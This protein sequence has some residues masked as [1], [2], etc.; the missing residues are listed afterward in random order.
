[1]TQAVAT[2]RDGDTFQARFFWQKAARMLIANTHISRVGF[3]K[4][5][6]GFDDVWVEYLGY[7]APK[8]FQGLSILRD[9]YQCKWHVT[10]GQYGYR[11]IVD[12]EFINATSHSLL[13]RAR[14]AQLQ[15]A[16]DGTGCRFRL[17]TNW[18]IAFDDPLRELI[19]QRAHNLRLDRMYQGTTARSA[20]GQLRQLW[21]DHLNIPDE[22][23][24]VL[25][26]TLAFTE[27]TESLDDGRDRLNELFHT[28]GLKPIRPNES[29]C[30]YDDLAFQWLAQGR[31]VFDRSTFYAACK[32]E[33]LLDQGHAAPIVFGVKSFEHPTDILEERC[34][35]V[36]NLLP[37]FYDRQIRPESAWETDLYP[38]LRAFLIASAKATDRLRLALDAHVT[39]A[40][41]TGTILD[42]KSGRIIEIEQRTGARQIWA[43]D[44]REPSKD[45]CSLVSTIEKSDETSHDI[46]VTV[47]LTRDVEPMVRSYM[48]STEL[49]YR[50]RLSA[51]P[52]SGP[53]SASVQCG[54]HAV[55]LAEEL[56]RRIGDQRAAIGFSGRVHLFLAVPNGFAFF[57]GQRLKPA[58]RVILYEYD[59]EGLNGGSYEPSLGLPVGS[60]NP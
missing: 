17:Y 33:G 45:W 8:D 38:E 22:A 1:M 54:R 30:I 41:A 32:E 56:M 9:H 7:A 47:S 43:P 16:P 42:V 39:L 26:R 51:V 23:L 55:D 40:V 44:D 48:E 28:A 49:K 3:E 25:A 29:S 36:L 24:R 35:A 37:K 57:L 13:Q 21:R 34:T 5:P 59:F 60:R 58:G 4:G 2:R 31:L 10:S 15:Y 12:P 20:S 50:V 53:G 14:Q 11:D 6:K 19:H 18:R 46:L 27:T 52:S